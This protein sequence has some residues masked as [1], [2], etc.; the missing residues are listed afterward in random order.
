MRSRTPRRRTASER[1]QGYAFSQTS[2]FQKVQL[3][4]TIRALP[5]HS[6]QH[7]LNHSADIHVLLQESLLNQGALYRQERDARIDGSPR[8]RGFCDILQNEPFALEPLTCRR[9]SSARCS[10]FSVALTARRASS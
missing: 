7:L 6:G 8:R 3:P 4:R 5:E 1:F 2:S 9:R 10:T